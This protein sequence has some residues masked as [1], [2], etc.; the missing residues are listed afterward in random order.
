M[1]EPAVGK[2]S[3]EASNR[4]SCDEFR[5]LSRTMHWRLYNFALVARA[6]DKDSRVQRR[7]I[8]GVLLGLLQH[9]SLVRY[10][11]ATSTGPAD[12]AN[13]RQAR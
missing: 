3:L 9:P 7:V 8:M 12:H 4:A 1:P 13:G 6:V 11:V 5:S 10:A 2:H